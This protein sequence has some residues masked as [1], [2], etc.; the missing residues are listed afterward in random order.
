MGSSS[1]GRLS[2]RCWKGEARKE[3]ENTLEKPG[4]LAVLGERYKEFTG[5]FPRKA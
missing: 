5:K 4:E 2:S 3:K 1:I